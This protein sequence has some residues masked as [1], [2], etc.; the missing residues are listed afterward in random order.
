MHLSRSLLRI[1]GLPLLIILFSMG[2]MLSPLLSKD[3]ALAMGVTYDL[4]LTVPL[5]YLFLIRN[6]SIPKITAIP[7]FVLG[8]V[9]ASLLLPEHQRY[10]LG[11]VTTYLLPV[12]ELVLLSVIFFYVHKAVRTFRQSAGESRDFYFILK[13]SAVRA[14]GYPRLGKV[15][16]SEIAMLYYALLAWKKTPKPRNSFT[17]YKENGIT[18]LLGTIIFIGTI[19]LFIAHILLIRWNETLAW[20]LFFGSLYGIFQILGHIRAIRRRYSEIKE[21]R[22]L[23]KYGLFGDMD[24]ELRHIQ[25]VELTTNPVNEADKKVEQLALLKAIES[26][27]VALYFTEKQTIEKAYGVSRECDVVLLHVDNKEE[28]VEKLNQALST[29]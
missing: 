1:Y 22:L 12:V 14:V 2:L 7:V 17:G 19:E 10:H 29:C 24:I 26:Y 9:L 15:F 6:K 21:N 8:I 4:T 13:E 3:P 25:R 5:V 16:A 18:A 28:F 20:V 27:N 23:L 11:L